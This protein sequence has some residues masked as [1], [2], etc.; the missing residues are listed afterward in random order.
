MF[1]FY[2]GVK[3]FLYK[4]FAYF[5]NSAKTKVL[6]TLLRAKANIKALKIIS[7]TENIFSKIKNIKQIGGCKYSHI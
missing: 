7:K 5:C 3:A 4:M 6:V 1:V 2:S